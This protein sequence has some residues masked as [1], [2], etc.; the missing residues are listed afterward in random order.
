MLPTR[1]RV[2]FQP[3]IA[4]SEL[5]MQYARA[6]AFLLRVRAK[7]IPRHYAT[8]IAHRWNLSA[9]EKDRLA[10]VIDRSDGSEARLAKIGTFC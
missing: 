10:R 7:Q 1:A 4:P 2:I 3:P 9:S 5:A 8:G 6:E